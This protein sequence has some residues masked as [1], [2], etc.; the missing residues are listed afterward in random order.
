MKKAIRV[1]SI[2]CVALLLVGIMS[3]SNG[4]GADGSEPDTWTKVTSLEQLKGTWEATETM[5]EESGDVTLSAKM[6]MRMEYPVT[7][8]GERGL[9]LSE[10]VDM[11]DY[12]DEMALSMEMD[13]DDLWQEMKDEMQEEGVE[14]SDGRP[15]TMTS[16]GFIPDEYVL[17]SFTINGIT[18][19]VNQSK[20]KLKLD[21]GDGDALIL[22]KK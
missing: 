7:V 10:I 16:A 6:T 19:F 11:T 1:C 5:T 21:Y 12:I 15:Y 9:K 22:N 14:F 4:S 8:D 2:L 17:E 13:A 18:L 20:T 3:C